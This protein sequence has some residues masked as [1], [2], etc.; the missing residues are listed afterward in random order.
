MKL[1]TMVYKTL[2][3]TGSY[4]EADLRLSFRIGKNPV[5]PRRG[6]NSIHNKIKCLLQRKLHSCEADP[7]LHTMSP[8]P[9]PLSLRQ[10]LEP[11]R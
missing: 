9:R 4:C 6:L 2:G 10:D 7:D 8:F 1:N 5:F 3:N 11:D